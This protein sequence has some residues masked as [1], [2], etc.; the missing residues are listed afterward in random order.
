M[1]MYFGDDCGTYVCLKEVV[2]YSFL[3]NGKLCVVMADDMQVEGGVAWFYLQANL[4]FSIPEEL[5][6]S[7][8]SAKTY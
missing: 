6:S 3:V 1:R 5:I 2:R 4:V 8:K 7:L